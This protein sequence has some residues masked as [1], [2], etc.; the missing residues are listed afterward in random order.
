MKSG[1]IFFLLLLVLPSWSEGAVRAGFPPQPLW[2]STEHATAGD[3]V[4]IFTVLY[5]ESEDAVEGNLVFTVDG[6]NIDSHTFSLDAGKSSIESA[7]WRA[8]A[9]NHTISAKIDGATDTGL[10]Q[11]V[12]LSNEKAG[13][14]SIAVADPPPPS[15]VIQAVS[16]VSNF[17]G[18]AAS[19]SLPIITSVVGS[20]YAATEAFRTS[21]VSYL[22]EKAAGNSS[23]DTAPEGEGKVPGA[24][25]RN[26]SSDAPDSSGFAAA[27][28]AKS[29]SRLSQVAAAAALF[30]FDSRPLFYLVLILLALGTLYW[31]G[32]KVRRQDS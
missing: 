4:T 12:A 7:E 9:G 14:V 26:T 28:S 5:N 18:S 19:T 13:S 1:F 30:F 11:T 22:K 10:A 23:G 25:T 32:K 3:T 6:K 31:L 17:V 8:T 16:T 21:A 2:L 27:T 29:S 20:M 15:Q 24:A